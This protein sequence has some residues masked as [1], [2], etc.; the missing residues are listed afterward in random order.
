MIVKGKYCYSYSTI[1]LRTE[2]AKRFRRFS[3][4]VAPSH[5][6][7]LKKIMDFFEWNGLNPSDESVN[8]ILDEIRKNRK[9]TEVAIKRTESSIAIIRNIEITQTRPSNAILALL[10]GEAPQKKRIAKAE[11]RP[12]SVPPQEKEQIEVM[13]P[14]RRLERVEWK[15]QSLREEFSYVM[16]NVRK[17]K[18]TFGKDYLKIEITEGEWERFKRSA[19]SDY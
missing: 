19:K 13:V 8:K 3:K 1:N 7:A 9:R 17:V 4:K 18:S 6:E 14:K 5:S 2:V 12:K 11:P 10:L 16:E 15:L